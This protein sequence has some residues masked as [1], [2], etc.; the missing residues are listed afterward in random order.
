MI[1]QFSGGKISRN[2]QRRCKLLQVIPESVF[3]PAVKLIKPNFPSPGFGST[4]IF[5][6]NEEKQV[7]FIYL[8]MYAVK[9]GVGMTKLRLTKKNY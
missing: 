5:N 8:S 7:V 2:G 1:G 3:V 6:W 9:G 4:F